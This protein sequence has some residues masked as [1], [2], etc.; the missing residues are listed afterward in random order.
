MSRNNAVRG[1]SSAL[2]SFLREN[3]IAAPPRNVFARATPQNIEN[4]ETIQE[5]VQSEPLPESIV[6]AQPQQTTAPKRKRAVKKKGDEL[7]NDDL[8]ASTKK[9]RP[10]PK[11]DPK[12]LTNVR[13]CERCYRRYMDWQLSP[14]CNACLIIGTVSKKTS[15]ATKHVAKKKEINAYQMTGESRV[16]VLPLRDL[17][18]KVCVSIVI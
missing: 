13:F 2:A 4:Q 10:V 12:D 11:C 3:G 16:V 9:S 7:E 14:L 6:G 17:C 15:K 18:I 5:L 8:L 1:P